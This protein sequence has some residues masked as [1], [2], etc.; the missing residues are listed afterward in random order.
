MPEAIPHGGAIKATIYYHGFAD[1]DG[2]YENGGVYITSVEGKPYLA[3][4]SEPRFAHTW[5]P[6]KD[7]PSDK[8][9][10]SITITVPSALTA[11]SNGTLIKTTHDAE[12]TTYVWSTQY[13]IATYLVSVAAAEY[14]EFSETYKRID[15]KEMPI[16]YYVFPEDFE[17]AKIDFQNTSKILEFFAATFCEY[18][19]INEKYGYAEVIG[20]VT[21]ENQTIS[22]IE[23]SLI[24]GTK[25]SEI[26]FVH[27]TAH[28]WW[29]NFVT[30]VNWK[31]TWLNEGFAT[32]AEALYLEHT[33]GRAAYDH[34]IRRMM[35]FKPGD[36]AGSVI[37]QTDTAFWDSFSARVYFK[38]AIVLHMLRSMMG[39]SA[40]F[41]AMK[42]YLSH[43]YQSVTTED[44]ISACETSYG[45]SLTW[46]FDQWVYAST[47]SIDRPELY[48]QWSADSSSNNHQV[49]IN[50]EQ[51][52]ASQLLYRLP[53][54][55][56]V[57]TQDSSY[58]FPVIDS[59]ATQ[60]FILN[61]P[62]KPTNIFID[63][64]NAVFKTFK[65]RN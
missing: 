37:G 61:V 24:T 54:S 2:A 10:A 33:E 64:E 48:Y 59:L 46:F 13:P 51:R 4:A 45:K 7:T 63:K 18:P 42:I 41:S 22:S 52:T 57:Q 55:I 17:N 20:D 25:Q 3:T 12:T 31:N 14:K 23:K 65:H 49:S 1:F 39:D 15:G 5:W 8:A 34:H 36:L 30:P 21:M 60:S 43:Q 40:F 29:G 56:S 11:V 44:F 9:T 47:D 32:Y 53:F 58:S 62:N 28:Q 16:T 50:L 38:G 26:T 35:S 19:F 6:C 27:E